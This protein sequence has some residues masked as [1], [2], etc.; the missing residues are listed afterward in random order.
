MQLWINIKPLFINRRGWQIGSKNSYTSVQV[1]YQTIR[2]TFILTLQH[3]NRQIC[4]FHV[5]FSS[6]PMPRVHLTLHQYLCATGE[7]LEPLLQRSN[8]STSMYKCW[9]HHYPPPICHLLR[10]RLESR[11]H[12]ILSSGD[13]PVKNGCISASENMI[14]WEGS[15]SNILLIRSKNCRWSSESC[16]M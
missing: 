11:P 5:A 9:R 7:L 14:L 15:N 2:N 13:R 6:P 10:S 3:I 4:A 1:N 16:S 12:S 8:W